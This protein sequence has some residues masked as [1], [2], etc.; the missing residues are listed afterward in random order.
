VPIRRDV[1]ASFDAA[2]ATAPRRAESRRTPQEL[3]S[4]LKLQVTHASAFI[5][6]VVPLGAVQC[7]QTTV[8]VTFRIMCRKEVGQSLQGQVRFVLGVRLQ[9]GDNRDCSIGAFSARRR[10]L[11]IFEVAAL[12]RLPDKH[13]HVRFDPFAGCL[14]EDRLRTP[15]GNSLLIVQRRAAS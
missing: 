6:N 2:L 13:A 7:E 10:G 4:I 14:E 5:L 3:E 1:K 12:T 15:Y 8:W 9:H 11:G